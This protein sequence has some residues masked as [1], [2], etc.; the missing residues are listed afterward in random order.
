MDQQK[1]RNLCKEEAH[2][3]KFIDHHFD[4]DTVIQAQV[5]PLEVDEIQNG[6]STSEE[7]VYIVS[8]NDHFFVLKKEKNTM[9]IIDTF[10]VYKAECR[11]ILASILLGEL[12]S[13]VERGINGD[14]PL[15]QLLQIEFHYVSPVQQK[16][17]GPSVVV[18]RRGHCKQRVYIKHQTCQVCI[19]KTGES[20]PELTL[21]DKVDI[22]D[23]V[24][25]QKVQDFLEL[26]KKREH[27]DVLQE[28]EEARILNEVEANQKRIK[29]DLEKQH[30][31]RQKDDLET[32]GDVAGKCINGKLTSTVLLNSANGLTN[33]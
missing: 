7:C 2:K 16:L 22:V 8:W 30:V 26:L 10:E 27:L 32:K 33:D 14:T 25:E 6:E 17:F 13:K 3:D 20:Y 28:S 12:Q 15:H 9:Y 1:W 18:L 31:L 29:K 24:F 5:R 21:A 11:G 19:L 4:L 23:R